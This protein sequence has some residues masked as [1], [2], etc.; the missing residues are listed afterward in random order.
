MGN[1][2][3]RGKGKAIRDLMAREPKIKGRLKKR[4]DGAMKR[5]AEEESMKELRYPTNKPKRRRPERPERDREFRP[6][7]LP[8][9]RPERP[10][11]NLRDKFMMTPIKKKDGGGEMMELKSLLSKAT[12]SGVGVSLEKLKKAL[13]KAKE[14]KPTGR[15]NTD[16]LKK[17][18]GMMGKGAGGPLGSS[19]FKNTEPKIKG[20]LGGPKTAPKRR[21]KLRKLI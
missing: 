12:F 10:R 6:M 14:M 3:T 18:M 1:I 4:I 5:R 8:M 13:K 15:I 21:T 20:R 7:P 19:L 16:D 9:P 11:P 17:A 2:S